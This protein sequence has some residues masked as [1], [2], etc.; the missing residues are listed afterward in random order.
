MYNEHTYSGL[1][2]QTFNI[3]ADCVFYVPEKYS[4]ED[5]DVLIRRV[6][7]KLESNL[8]R[9]TTI[10]RYI[11]PSIIDINVRRDEQKI[12][13]YMQAVKN[14]SLAELHLE[15]ASEWHPTKNGDLLPT[16]FTPGSDFLAHWKC[17]KCGHEWLATIGH[18]VAGTGCPRCY[19]EGLKLKHPNDTPIYQYKIDGTFIKEWRSAAEA[20]K[21]L[22]INPHNISTCANHKRKR[23][24][25]YRWEYKKIEMLEPI[26]KKRT[27]T[28]LQMD[29]DGNIIKEF[30]SLNEAS[31]TLQIDA[32]TISH[33]LHGRL[34][35]AG[36]FCWKFKDL[37]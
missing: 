15:L 5:L 31:Q 10:P 34:K 27:K 30:D 32:T 9:L 18:R 12:R 25:D 16:M 11:A 8:Y 26:I 24:G 35:H 19:R 22:K 7:D 4:K 21:F 2:K 1:A 6:L 29:D 37:I 13:K 20:G 23:A 36:G 14:K 3:D 17:G 33:V 28:I